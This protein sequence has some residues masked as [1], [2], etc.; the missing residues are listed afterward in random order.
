MTE[1][2]AADLQSCRDAFDLFD[3]NRD[4]VISIDELGTVMRSLGQNPS[5][6]EVKELYD[7][8][9]TDNSGGITFE[10]FVK[11]WST[12]NEDGETEEEVIDAFRVFDNDA[13]GK[14]PATELANQMKSLGDPMSQEDIDDMILQ[15][16]KDQNGLIDYVEFVKRMIHP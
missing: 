16:G 2:S 1:L 15:A 4:G 8:I 6:K 3:R 10:E 7:A 9:D 5:E 13:D 12:Q 11:L 14:I